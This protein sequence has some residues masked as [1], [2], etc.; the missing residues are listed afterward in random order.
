[1]GKS[2][3]HKTS[4]RALTLVVDTSAWIKLADSPSG[5]GLL[6]HLEELIGTQKVRLFVPA[7]VLEEFKVGLP[8]TKER[9]RNRLTTSLDTAARFVSLYGPPDERLGL[10]VVL[11]D[12]RRKKE[13]LSDMVQAHADHVLEVMEQG[14]TIDADDPQIS[15]RA[16]ERQCLGWAPCH[17]P[18][19]PSANDSLIFETFAALVTESPGPHAFVADNPK[20]FSDPGDP[21]SPHPDLL[22]VFGKGARYFHSLSTCLEALGR[23]EAWQ[24]AVEDDLTT[25]PRLDAVGDLRAA[26]DEA[27]WQYRRDLLELGLDVYHPTEATTQAIAALPGHLQLPEPCFNQLGRIEGAFAVLHWVLYGD[28]DGC[29]D[30]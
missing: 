8:M 4:A 30:T 14:L 23:V 25:V 2:S 24:L 3:S 13:E 17:H 5:G 10:A 7:V 15:R 28:W 18:G 12:L 27:L 19:K 22:G 1:M 20:D 26:L 6:E 11:T 29:L 21:A 16:K 9:L